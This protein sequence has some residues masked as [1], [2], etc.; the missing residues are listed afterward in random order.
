MPVKNVQEVIRYP[1]ISE[2]AV[3]LIE[4]ENKIT[5]IVD[6]EASKNDI[7][8]AVEELYEVKVDRVNSV[9][10]PEGRKKAFVKLAPD[11]KASDLAVRLGVL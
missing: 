4:S 6:V 10:T 2:D 11:Y 7:R 5:F 1:L 9:L 3:T 8:R